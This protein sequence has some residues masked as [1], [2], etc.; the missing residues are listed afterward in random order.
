M[1][2]QKVQNHFQN[3]RDVRNHKAKDNSC[4][5]I[6]GEDRHSDCKADVR[7]GKKNACYYGKSIVSRIKNCP[8]AKFAA[9]KTPIMIPLISMTNRYAADIVKTIER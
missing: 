5:G 8:H 4:N 7:H 3:L 2:P 1:N 9:C 6:S